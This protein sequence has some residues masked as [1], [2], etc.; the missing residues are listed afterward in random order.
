MPTTTDTV[1]APLDRRGAGDPARR[2]PRHHDLED[3]VPREPGAHRPRAHAVG[4]PEVLRPDIDRLRWILHQQK[5]NFLP[6]KV[7]KDRLDDA[8][9]DELPGRRRPEA[10]PEPRA[11]AATKAAA[12]AEPEQGRAAGPRRRRSEDARTEGG[13]R[14]AEAGVTPCRRRSRR[15]EAKVQQPSDDTADAGA[16]RRRRR[17]P[18]RP[19]TATAP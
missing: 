19:A 8:G 12:K 15:A 14:P 1:R 5:E 4:V 7:I 9:P 18:R 6:L 2:V 13:R 17:R 10:P 3:P 11:E 16:R